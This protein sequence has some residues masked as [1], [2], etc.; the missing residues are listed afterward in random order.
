ME[1]EEVKKVEETQV[2]A[3]EI[4]W[5]FGLGKAIKEMQGA[6]PSFEIDLGI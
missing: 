3:E 4:T 1:N 6:M 5:D 2:E